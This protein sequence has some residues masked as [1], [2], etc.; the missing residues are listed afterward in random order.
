SDVPLGSGNS[1]NVPTARLG[2]TVSPLFEVG[3]RLPDSLGFFALNYRFFDTDGHQTLDIN[4]EPFDVKSRLSVN[5]WDLDY[6]TAPYLFA[7]GWQIGWRIGIRMLDVFYDARI[8]DGVT[9]QASNSFFG[10]GPH[11]RLDLQRNFGVVP[12]LGVFTS[13]DGAVIVGHTRET[14]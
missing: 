11:A 2:W 3:Y 6:G 4:G 13:L 10:A 8:A 1:L 14:F 12:G 9:Q 5:M 7:P